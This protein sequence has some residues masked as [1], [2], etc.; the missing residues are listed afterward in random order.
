LFDTE[1]KR[2]LALAHLKEQAHKDASLG[3]FYVRNRGLSGENERG[4]L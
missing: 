3:A 1:K 2:F 4:R